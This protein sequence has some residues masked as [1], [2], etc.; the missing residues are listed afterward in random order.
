MSELQSR[1]R[2]L[3]LTLLALSLPATD[4][5]VLFPKVV[6]KANELA[7]ELEEAMDR[8]TMSNF[9]GL[10]PRQRDAIQQLDNFVRQIPKDD[11]I[12]SD[13]GLQG[14]SEWEEVRRLARLAL[15]SGDWPATQSYDMRYFFG[16]PDDE[17]RYTELIERLDKTR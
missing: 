15:S 1:L 2:R 7:L 10:E 6:S 8:M 17:D 9:Q 3:Y 16:P 13:E 14:A 4:Q 5:M 12:W 11:R